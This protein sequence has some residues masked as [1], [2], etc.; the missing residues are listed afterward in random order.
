MINKENFDWDGMYLMYNGAYK[1][2]K[3]YGEVYGADKCHP[4]RVDMLKP[5]FIARFKYGRK[6]VKSFINF[7]VK[8][9]SSIEEYLAEAERTSPLE[10]VESR[11]FK[12][13]Q[14]RKRA[15]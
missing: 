13:F 3:T 4:S 10:A 6:P 5:A 9:F 14:P 7:I 8:N 15:A 2:A 1:G 11:G 12:G